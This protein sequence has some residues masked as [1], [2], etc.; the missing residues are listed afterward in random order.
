[1]P[2]QPEGPA[3]TTYHLWVPLTP[4]ILRAMIGARYAVNIDPLATNTRRGSR[5]TTTSYPDY[6][7]LYDRFYPTE[8]TSGTPNDE[9]TGE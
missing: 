3:G 7:A 8:T 4:A 5:V 9:P 6:K 1:V 2:A